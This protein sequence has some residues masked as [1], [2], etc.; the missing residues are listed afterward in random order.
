MDFDGVVFEY[1]NASRNTL[2]LANN[3]VKDIRIQNNSK[4]QP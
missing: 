4:T 2:S 3:G 1:C